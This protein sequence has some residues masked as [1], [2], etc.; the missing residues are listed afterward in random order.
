M[1]RVWCR[2]D[3]GDGHPVS[4]GGSPRR[5]AKPR[6][7]GNPLPRCQGGGQPCPALPVPQNLLRVGSALLDSSNK[8]HWELIQQTEGGTAWLLKHFE[9]YASALAQNMPQTYLSP[10]T[11]VTPNIG[12]RGPRVGDTCV[13]GRGVCWGPGCAW[14]RCQGSCTVVA[15]VHGWRGLCFLGCAGSGGARHAGCRGPLVTR[16]RSGVGGAAG[17]GQLCGRPAAAVRGVA[18]GEATGPGD[19]R[20]PARQRLPAPRGQA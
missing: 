19:H 7:G 13:A 15:G 5:E 14:G 10:F 16:C 8:R 20:H 11:I 1:C 17:Q 9:D 3:Q 4:W 2:R 6:E 12:E 18:G